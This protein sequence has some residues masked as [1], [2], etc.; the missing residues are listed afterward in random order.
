[1]PRWF[2]DFVGY[3][4][5]RLSPSRAVDAMREF[6]DHVNAVGSASPVRLVI[7]PPTRVRRLLV[8]F[9]ESRGLVPVTEDEDRRRGSERRRRR[10]AE[11]PEVLRPAVSQFAAMLDDRRQR[12]VRLGLRVDESSTVESRLATV[13]DLARFCVSSRAA[14][15][16]WETVARADVEAFLARRRTPSH[17]ELA[18][19]RNFFRW[20]RRRRL[21]LAN[22]TDGL[23]ICQP[24]SFRGRVLEPAE[25]RRLYR[26][27]SH[28]GDVHPHE[29]FFGLAALVHGVSTAEIRELRVDD[30]DQAGRSVRLGRRRRRVTLDPDTWDALERCLALRRRLRGENPHVIVTWRSAS[31]DGPAGL[32]YLAGLLTPASTSPA[33]LRATRLSALASQADPIVI[34]AV[35]GVT[36]KAAAYYRNEDLSPIYHD[37]LTR[38]L[39]GP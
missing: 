3:V 22:P 28:S 36:H 17:N 23:R 7:D 12:A 35:F 30:I 5:V 20:A 13:R 1:M 32:A 27:W 9:L 21:V 29:A 18:D 11:V 34:A 8:G 15:T 4:A 26:R 14:I 19:L 25:Q 2:H 37:R 6:G 38:L 31:T 10:V 24:A 39:P 33:T 16:G